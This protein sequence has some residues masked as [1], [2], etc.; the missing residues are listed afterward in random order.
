MFAAP[1]PQTTPLDKDATNNPPPSSGPFVITRVDAPNTLTLER[2]PQFK[3][4]KDAGATEVADAQVDKIIVTQN[5][6]NSAQVTGVQ[7]NTIDYMTDPPDADRLPEIKAKYASR[8]R[9]EDSINTYYFWMNTQKAPFNDLKVRQAINYAIDPEALNRVFGAACTHS[10]DPAARH[11]RP[12]RI[13]AVRGPGHGQGQG[14]DRRGQ[15]G[16]QGHHVWTDDEPD[17]KRIGEYYHDLLTQLGFNATLKVISGDTYFQTI[18]NEST[19]SGHRFRGLVPGLPTPGRLLPPAAQ[20][21]RTSCRPTATISPGSR[22]PS[23]MPSRTSCCRSNSPTTSASSTPRWT[24]PTW[25]RR[26]G[27]RTATSSTRRSFPSGWT[28]TSPIG[29][30]CSTRT[31]PPSR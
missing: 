10:A 30:C 26:C 29:I 20:L 4:V 11:A 24:R 9:M 21:A 15:S 23:S 28:S 12:R 8:F 27:R 16:R 13:Q 18:G 3:T 25:S 17:R 14:P 6:N 2:N 1:V 5:K 19:G 31:T 22:S 7:Q